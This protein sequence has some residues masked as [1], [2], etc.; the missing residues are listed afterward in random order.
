[1]DIPDEFVPRVVAA[2]EHIAAYM[3]ATDRDQQPYQEV[4][5]FMKRKA[6]G[7]EEAAPPVLKKK[8]A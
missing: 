4:L 8:R 3:K 2:L 7:K 5:D 6:P 1:M